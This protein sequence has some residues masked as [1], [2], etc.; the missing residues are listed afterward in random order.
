MRVAMIDPSLFTWPYD[1]ALAQG[2]ADIGNQ[3]LVFGKALPAGH[4]DGRDP[5]LRQHFYPGLARPFFGRLPRSAMRAAKGLSHIGSMARLLRVL[6]AWRPDVIHFQWCPLPAVDGRFLPLFRKIAPIVLTVH[7]TLP[8]NGAPGSRLQNLGSLAVL[9]AFDHLIVHT[10]QGIA[11]VSAHLGAADRITP[12]PHGLLHE[13][14]GSLP[15]APQSASDGPITFLLFG[16]VKPYKGV[17]VLLRALARVAPEHRAR[18]RVRIVGKPYMDIAP[19]LELARRMGVADMV[20]FDFR[21]VPDAEMMSMMDEASV[22]VFPY[23]EIEASG[24]LMAAIARARPVIASRLGAF[25]EL[26]ES[27]SEGLLVPPGD[28]IALAEAIDRTLCQPGLLQ[29]MTGG[30]ERLRRS[31]PN[32]QEIARRS[33]D[34]YGVAERHWRN[35]VSTA[36]NDATLKPETSVSAQRR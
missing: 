25:A 15:A 13:E 18:C 3:V 20:A 17:D 34:V 23:R 26:I 28:E 4:V 21:F 33:V 1:R 19:L 16:Q 11:R 29:R 7:D 22:L 12:I 2:H 36:A 9:R 31:I 27:G 24:V 35:G 5:L 14:S 10:D 30:M 6:S 32:W 8:F